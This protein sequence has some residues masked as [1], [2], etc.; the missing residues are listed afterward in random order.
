M[1][2]IHT[3]LMARWHL[4]LCRHWA[5]IKLENVL[6]G[7]KSLSK[8]VLTSYH[9]DP[10]KNVKLELLCL[11]LFHKNL[12]KFST[13]YADPGKISTHVIIMKSSFWEDY[14]CPEIVI[15]S[16]NHD[17]FITLTCLFKQLLWA[18]SMDLITY[19]HWWCVLLIMLNKIGDIRRYKI[20]Q[21]MLF[22]KRSMFVMN[23]MTS[24]WTPNHSDWL[25]GTCAITKLLNV[26]K[27]N[28]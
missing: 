16:P 5:I 28:K 18:D 8:Q 2:V 24:S 12:L 6:L 13:E 15:W 10:M 14:Q 26:W 1:T 9:W 21:R 3:L 4:R 25:Q 27:T 7:A 20:S 19:N 17:L 22:L 23:I 11:F